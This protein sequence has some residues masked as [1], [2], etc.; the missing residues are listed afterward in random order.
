MTEQEIRAVFDELRRIGVDFERPPGLALGTGFRPGE[1]LT[2]LRAL[3]DALGHDPFVDLLKAHVETAAPL[4]AAEKAARTASTSTLASFLECAT[5]EQLEAA[6]DVLVDEWDP[7][8]ARLGDLSRADVAQTAFDIV[9]A[10]L[11]DSDAGVERRIASAIGHVE[12]QEFGVRPSP[13][14]QRRYLARRLI[15]VVI[16][17]PAPN[18]HH[19]RAMPGGSSNSVELGPRGDELPALDAEASCSQCGTVGTVAVVMRDTEPLV[20]RYC[21]DC[22]HSVRDR[23]WVRTS[24]TVDTST[25]EGTIAAF[26]RTRSM[27][28]DQARYAASALWEDTLDFV[29][30]SLA[31]SDRDTVSDHE[32]QLGHLADELLKQAPKMYGPMPPAIEAFVQQYGRPHA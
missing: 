30:A 32:R 28:L 11:A 17:H 9:N 31:P 10:I 8:G 22:W 2:W 5:R 7:L 15:G 18:E 1:F 13:A 16:D 12:E 3:P 21:V 6:I 14:E 25:P 20:S 19:V 23:Y 29:R 24:P 4:P 26:D 27:A